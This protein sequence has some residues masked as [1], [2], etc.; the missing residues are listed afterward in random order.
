MYGFSIFC[1][2]LLGLTPHMEKG[3]T[4]R[5]RGGVPLRGDIE[6]RGSKNAATP[7]LAATLLT[8]EPCRIENIPRIKDVESMLNVIEH[9]G[10]DISWEGD[11]TVVIRA[12][13]INPTISE[14]TRL[15]MRRMRSSVLFIGALLARFGEVRLPYPGGCDIGERSIDTH[16]KAFRDVGCQIREDEK[17]VELSWSS[18]GIP[19]D[20]ILEEFSVTATEN[21]LLALA[22]IPTPTTIHIAAAEPHVQDLAYFLKKMGVAIE[23]IG[24]HDLT[25]KG[26]ES[27]KGAEHRLISDFI[28]AGTFILAALATKGEVCIQNADP[29]HLFLVL[30]V[31]KDAGAHIDVGVGG[32]LWV[33]PAKDLILKRVQTLPYPGIPTDLQSLFAVLAT[34]TKGPTLLHDPM[35]GGR[36]HAVKELTKLGARIEILDDHRA[37]IGGPST[38]KGALLKGMELRGTAALVMAGLVAEGETMVEGADQI[39]RGYEDIDGRLRNLG[40]QIERV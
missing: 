16:L 4:F 22:K 17:W 12:E 30:K 38:L 1:K 28:E 21:L 13:N 35:Y 34:Q 36:L 9:L 26:S 6:V 10:A 11:H 31:L 7:I 40:A 2:P 3:N 32:L 39:A 5:I 18:S 24:S 33:R 25:V 27:L 29:R 20:V 19:A 14:E 23:G 15:I 8:E 37:L